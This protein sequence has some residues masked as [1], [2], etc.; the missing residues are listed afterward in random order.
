MRI[1]IKNIGIVANADVQIDGIS[2]IAGKNGTG[3]STISKALYAAFNGF[4]NYDQ[5]VERERETIVLRYLR[6][7]EMDLLELNKF[8]EDL[9]SLLRFILKNKEN[10]TK[11][12]VDLEKKLTDFFGISSDEQSINTI[13]ST[14][15]KIIDTLK[16]EKQQII[17]RMVARRFDSEFAGQVKNVYNEDNGEITLSVRD[18]DIRF[19]FSNSTVSLMHI[20]A[21]FEKEAIYIDDSSVLDENIYR[22]PIKQYNH[23]S[24]LTRKLFSSTETDE[25]TLDTILSEIKLKQAIE[26]INSAS[27]GHLT[28]NNKTAFGY[29]LEDGNIIDIKNTS[30]GLKTFAIIKALLLSGEISENGDRK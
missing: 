18:D 24:E 11:N 10:Y 2:V 8:P 9:N 30:E 22:V 5:R 17:L 4:N 16:I 14:A 13:K 3:K 19:T 7:L 26:I 23:R 1:R 12:P 6:N 20:P 15:E 25:L 27:S 29:E 21:I 28:S